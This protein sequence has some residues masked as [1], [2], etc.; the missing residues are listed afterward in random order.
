M[1]AAR[2]IPPAARAE[3]LQAVA[4][5]LA[6]HPGELGPGVVHRIAAAAQ[7]QYFDPPD[8]AG[9]GSPSKYR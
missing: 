4:T 5:A 3:F 1:N 8:P 9:I 2:P 6:A 7:R